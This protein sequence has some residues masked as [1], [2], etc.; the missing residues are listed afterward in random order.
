MICL[1]YYLKLL[2][3]SNIAIF[4]YKFIVYN[5]RYIFI[6]LNLGYLYATIIYLHT[7]YTKRQLL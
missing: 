7:L 2:S 5:L 4:V 6:I 3:F 1:Y